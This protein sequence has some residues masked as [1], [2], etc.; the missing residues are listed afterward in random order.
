MRIAV[1][2]ETRD[3]EARV[4]M[5]PELVGK[6]TGLGYDV[7]VEPRAGLHALIADD[8]YLGA[9]AGVGSPRSTVP[10]W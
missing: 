7:V 3:G 9:G 4:A 8:D 2:K 1:A 5:V 6:L 10:R